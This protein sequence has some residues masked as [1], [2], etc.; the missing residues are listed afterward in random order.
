MSHPSLISVRPVPGAPM[1][2]LGTAEAGAVTVVRAC[3]ELDRDT[4]PALT[5]HVDQ[6]VAGHSPLLLVLDL[7]G[8]DYLGAAGITALLHV[9]DTL[10]RRGGRL[11]L[12]EP[13]PQVRKVLELG[14]VA[15]LFDVDRTC[16]T[17]GIHI[18]PQI[19]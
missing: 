18:P 16:E 4:A 2:T 8:V 13:S 6:L 1:F 3:G 17:S 10:T 12:Q 7:A 19:G 5:Q 11:V 9:R 15:G 14:Q